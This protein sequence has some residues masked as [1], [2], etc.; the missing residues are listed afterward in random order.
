[1]GSLGVLK[2]V[3]LVTLSEEQAN[4]KCRKYNFLYLWWDAYSKYNSDTILLTDPGLQEV[5]KATKLSHP[6]SLI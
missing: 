5:S 3:K 4:S 1:M 6:H 2:Y